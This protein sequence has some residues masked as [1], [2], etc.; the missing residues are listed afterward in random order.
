MIS[1]DINTVNIEL[2]AYCVAMS[3]IKVECNIT[4][5]HY[6]EKR[7]HVLCIHVK[8]KIDLAKLI[9]F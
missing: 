8:K 4:N 9:L 7:I 3:A 6:R 1:F 2:G 5:R